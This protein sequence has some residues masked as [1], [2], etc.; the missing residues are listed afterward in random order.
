ME[1]YLLW[2]VF[3]AETLVLYYKPKFLYKLLQIIK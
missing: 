1:L 3:Y 2:Y